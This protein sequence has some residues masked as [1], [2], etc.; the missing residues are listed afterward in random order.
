MNPVLERQ[1]KHTIRFYKIGYCATE[2][3]H[4]RSGIDTTLKL[5][6]DSTF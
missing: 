2:F 3:S 1:S 4:N 5:N 6:K